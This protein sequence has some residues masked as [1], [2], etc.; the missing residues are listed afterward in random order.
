MA[1]FVPSDPVKRGTSFAPKSDACQTLREL[2][3]HHPAQCV[4]SHRIF[5]N[6]VEESKQMTVQSLLRRSCKFLEC[7]ISRI[8]RML[9]LDN[10]WR[11]EDGGWRMED[12]VGCARHA[13][14]S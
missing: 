9:G 13:A 5:S 14:A 8:S 12:G 6:R 1:G 4:D 10:G 2:I 3:K 7:V 11:M